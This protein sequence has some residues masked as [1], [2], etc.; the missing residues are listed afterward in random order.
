[1][2]EQ[3]ALV[4]DIGG[5]NARLAVCELSTGEVSNP[6]TYPT[7]DYDSLELVMRD[8]CS[9][10]N[11]KIDFACIAIACPVT[12]D[13]VSMTNHHWAFSISEMKHNLGLSELKVINDFTAVA[14]A[15][16]QLKAD[17]RIQI[18]GKDPVEGKPIAIYGAGTGLGVAQLVNI[19]GFWHSIPGEGGHVDL[20]P[21]TPE[22]DELI[23]YLRAIFGRVSA[24]RCLSGQG[25]ENIYQFVASQNPSALPNLEAKQIAQQ[26][27]DASNQDCVRTLQLFSILM[28]RFGGNL[29]L[30]SGAFGGVYIA[31]GIVPRFIEFFIDSGFREAF[32]DKGRFVD[33]LKDIPAYVVTHKELGLVG[34]GAYLKQSLASSPM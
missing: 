23:Q 3:Y 20:A 24:E 29:A 17:E 11:G 15:I 30:T 12:D 34:A 14:F 33:Y 26:A 18:G 25:I 5:T 8:Y 21:C 32:E 1:M 2:S 16:P 27:L 22:E 19:E 10:F 9:K 28:G 4:G 7:S 31:G 6:I 13:W